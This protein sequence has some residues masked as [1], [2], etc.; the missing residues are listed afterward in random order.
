L[1]NPR[2]GMMA[3]AAA[4]PA[5]NFVLAAVAAIIL[6]L[7]T[8]SYGAAEPGAVAVFLATSLNYFLMINIFLGFFNLLPVPPFDGSHIVEGLLPRKAAQV[9][10]RLRPLGFPILFLLLLVVPYLFPQANIVERLVLPPVDWLR[11]HYYTLAQ[12]VAGG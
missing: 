7:M 10:N 8:R 12:A 4:G 6:G 5:T 2:F 11:A 1:R 3:V 9:Y